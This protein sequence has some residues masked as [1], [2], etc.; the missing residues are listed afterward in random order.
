MCG[1]CGKYCSSGVEE[2]EVRRMAKAL[3]HRG[4]DDEGYYLKGPIGL[5]HR[6]LSIIDLNTGRQPLANEDGSIWIIFNGEIYNYRSLKRDLEE[7]GHRFQTQ[8]DTEVIVH[9]YEDYGAGCLDHLRGMFAFA[10]WDEKQRTLFLARDRIGQ[11]PLFY[12]QEGDSFWFA[13]ELK[14]LLTAP[15]IKRELDL[16]ALHH[17]LS[18][19]FIPP[20]QTMFRSIHKLP[21]GHYLIFR[22]GRI[23]IRRYWDLSFRDKLGGKDEEYVERLRA[24]MTETVQSHLVSDVPVGAFLSGGMDSSIIVALMAGLLPGRFKTF[25]IGVKEQDFNELPYARMV[26]DRFRTEHIEEVVEADLIGLLPRIIWHLDEPSD[27]IA[28][29]FF[30]ASRLA[31]SQVKVVL[32]GDGGDEL[33]A[34]FDRYSGIRYIDYYALVPRWVREKIFG[35]LIDRM[36]ENFSYKSLSQRIRW[37]QQLAAFDGGQRYAEATSFFR[38][39]HRDK[40]ALFPPDLWKSL[41]GLDSN[42]VIAGPYQR[43][44]AEDPIDRMLYADLMTK[45]PEHTLMLTDRLN[46]AHGLEARSPFLDHELMELVAAFPSRIKIKGRRLKA[47]LREMAQDLLPGEIL[48]R[49]KQG[50]MFPV[51]YWFRQP[52]YG[53]LQTFFQEARL[54]REGVINRKQVFKL[55]E[56]HRRNKLDHH[57]RLW[58]LLNLEIWYRLYLEQQSIEEI[59]GSIREQMRSAGS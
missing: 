49:G 25:A 39:N 16:E 7:K 47:V 17:Y 1:I 15:E 45:L 13:S 43:A 29:C 4:P 20:P 23:T 59:E 36:P 51:A 57:V 44:P 48:R 2:A 21:P 9:L 22:E 33:F 5:G 35:A 38:F 12:A 32:G 24:K 3:A 18:L 54:I 27:P 6:R 46:M 34:G 52:L 11:K 41:A 10:L 53:F 37:M 58:M 56:E 50:F 26:A 14:G 31:S 19:R 30:Q 28:A 40:A 8:T 55:L 42:E